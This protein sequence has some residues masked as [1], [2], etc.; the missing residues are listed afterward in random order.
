ML[1]TKSILM[2]GN[3]VVFC[4]PLLSR[5]LLLLY[6]ASLSFGMLIFEC[7]IEEISYFVVRSP[8]S[9]SRVTEKE[10]RSS[11]EVSRTM[12]SM[13]WKDNNSQ[14]NSRKLLSQIKIF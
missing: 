14:L 4:L 6:N 1:R 10:I 13:N 3:V 9:H 11:S 12:F 5:S 8:T 2:S 7:S